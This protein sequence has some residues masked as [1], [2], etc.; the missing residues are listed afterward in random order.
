MQGG[1][2]EVRCCAGGEACV[3][4]D[5]HQH[6]LSRYGYGYGLR[7]ATVWAA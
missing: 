1:L 4:I 5:T 7:V 2:P 3:C 6:A